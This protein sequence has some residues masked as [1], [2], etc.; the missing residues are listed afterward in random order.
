MKHF[1]LTIGLCLCTIGVAVGQ[2]TIYSEDFTGEDGKG[3]TGTS[4]GTTFD[5]TGVTW[6]ID[7]GTTLETDGST[8]QFEVVSGVF[9]GIDVDGSAFWFSPE[10]DVTSY[11]AIDLSVDL[12]IIGGGANASGENITVYYTLNPS[13]GTPTYTSADSYTQSNDSE[14]PKSISIS[15]ID[16][17]GTNEFGIRIEMDANGGGDGFSFDNVSVEENTV[18]AEPTNHPTSFSATKDG[19][20]EIDLSWTDA[21]GAVTPDA[22]LVKVS[23]TS[24]AAIS[25]PS[26]G[27]AESDDS[28]V[29][30][31]SG[32]L[33]VNQGTES[34]SFTGLSDDTQY[35]FKI[36]SYTNSG[37]NID[38]KTNG[39]IQS[40]DATTDD[41]PDVVIN[42]IMADPTGLDTNGDGSSNFEEDEFVEIVNT[43]TSN[44]DISSWVI[45]D[46]SSDRHTF[47]ASTVLAPGQAVV[48][49][50][51]GT[52]TGDFGGSLTF[53]ATSGKFE[54]N[55]SGD[56]VVLKNNSGTTIKSVTYGS[57]GGSD[58]S[59]TRSPDLTGSFAQHE[60]ADTDDASSFSPGTKLDGT[61][62][63]EELTI[64]GTEGWRM[65]S[66]PNSDNTYDDLLGDIW[67]QGI[68]TGAD[69]TNGTAS[70]QLYNTTTDN[71][72]AATDLGATMTTGVGFITYVYSDD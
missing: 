72:A 10:I 26:D 55:N 66:T 27:T 19:F 67:T 32:A 54:L 1:L 51:G 5:T 59:L 25:D 47:A 43:G 69:V 6:T 34:G 21:T 53:T 2:T 68:G 57:E 71:F 3:A 12:D 7:V 50:G 62:F 38:F 42:E 37:S 46:N 40:D 14:L 56:D 65:L 18:K 30:D 8:N 16:V 45:A 23:S 9:S 39:T 29:S 63:G 15:N 49:F 28:D 58:E 52:P 61:S 13:A 24:L 35:F 44:L 20:S 64:S 22:Y 60:T 11:S 4:S 41:A 17:S 36:Y 48:V 33:N 31:G 70:V